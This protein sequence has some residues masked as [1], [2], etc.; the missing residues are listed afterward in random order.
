M[1]RHLLTFLLLAVTLTSIVSCSHSDKSGLAIP[2][3]AAFALH[4]NVKSLTSKLSWQEIQQNEWFKEAY[5][6]ETDSFVK[7]TLQDPATSGVDIQSDLGLFVKKQNQGGYMAVEGGIKDAAA[8]ETFATNA[9]KGGKVVKSGDVSVLNTGLKSLVAWTKSRFVFISDVPMGSLANRFNS[10]ASGYE[11]F[12][13]TT[14]SLQKFAMELF[15]LPSKNNLVSDERFVSVMKEPGDIHYWVNAEQYYNSLGGMMSLL[16]MNSLFEGNAYG[17]ALNFA[18]GKITFKTKA[19]VNKELKALMEK[20]GGGKISADMINRIPS[21][22]VVAVFA[23]KYQPQGFIDLL[24]MMGVDGMVNGFL[25]SEGYST[26][27]F[28][29]ATKGDV[30]LAVSDLKIKGKTTPGINPDGSPAIEQDILPVNILFASSVNEKPSFDKLFSILQKKSQELQPIT[31]NVHFQ[32]NNDWFAAGNS[33]EQVNAFLS[34]GNNNFAFTSRLAGK[35]FG[36][37][38]DLQGII[39]TMAPSTTDSVSKATMDLSTNM[40]QDVYMYSDGQK[41]DAFVGEMEINLVDKST[42]SL[43]LLNTYLDSMAKIT[44]PRRNHTDAHVRYTDPASEG[45]AALEPVLHQ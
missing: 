5:T 30:L 27:E 31:N 10:N 42:N 1:Q 12:S 28:V 16:K 23:F 13:F 9:N 26:A 8:F 19:F 38:I 4:V 21:K 44:G 41:D 45:L 15:D 29:K 22:N 34:G 2:R 14:D 3:D 11:P 25:G 18:N 35:S 43:K 20:N 40:W 6:T 36:G 39:K 33:P 37:Y 32:L 17:A 7:K 24:K